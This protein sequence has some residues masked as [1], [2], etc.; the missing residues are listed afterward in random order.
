VSLGVV[1]GSVGRALGPA[2]SALGVQLSV[3]APRGLPGQA[4]SPGWP[5]SPAASLEPSCH[6]PAWVLADADR[7]AQVLTN[8]VENALDHARSAVVVRVAAGGGPAE[9]GSPAGSAGGASGIPVTVE[10]D[11]PGIAPAELPRVW[12]PYV[13]RPGRRR[14][15]TG[16]GL[17]IVDEL[18]RS[19]GGAVT[20]ESPIGA[21]GGTRMTV[22]VPQAPAP[23]G[24][25]PLEGA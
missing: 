25:P 23:S 17:A 18:V 11:G 19:M 8:L 21:G 12:A 1:G 7:L 13:T 22:V 15:G 9:P 2:A 20:A 14:L 16:L 24:G 10:D 3:E 4:G 6:R 5:G